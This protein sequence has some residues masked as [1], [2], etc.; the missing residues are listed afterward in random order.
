MIN[1]SDLL[2][3]KQTWAKKLIQSQLFQL[4][5]VLLGIFVYFLTGE[6]RNREKFDYTQPANYLSSKLVFFSVKK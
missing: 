1:N 6:K 3:L 5:N 2:S 4:Q